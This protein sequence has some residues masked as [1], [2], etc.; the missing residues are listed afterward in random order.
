MRDPNRIDP[1][2]AKLAATWKRYPNLRFGQLIENIA[3]YL[4]PVGANATWYNEEPSW[5]DAMDAM[6]AS[7]HLLRE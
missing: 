1:F 6:D 7:P 3:V 5:E 2:L 4:R